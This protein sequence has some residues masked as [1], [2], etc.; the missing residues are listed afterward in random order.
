M[1]KLRLNFNRFSDADL[2][3][4]A[5]AIVTAVTNNAGYFPTPVPALATLTDVIGSYMASLV[6]AKAGGRTAVALKNMWRGQVTALFVQLGNYIMLTAAGDKT[7]LIASGFDL[8]KSPEP[9]PPLEKPASFQVVEGINIGEFFMKVK[10]QKS[11]KSYQ[12]QVSATDPSV[13]EDAAWIS[14]VTSKCKVTFPGLESGKRYWCR[15]G[16]TGPFEQQVYSDVITKI[17]Q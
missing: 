15:A 1:E 8:A 4:K 9:S 13:S 5:E 17:A 14:Q 11:A 6:E 7:I 10:R 16:I 3:T 2:G 12:F